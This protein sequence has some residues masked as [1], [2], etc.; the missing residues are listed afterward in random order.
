MPR[1]LQGRTYRGL[2]AGA[3]AGLTAWLLIEK[4]GWFTALL[5][6]TIGIAAG[7]RLYW[8]QAALGALYG[9]VVAAGVC[10]SDWSDQTGKTER[11]RMLALSGLA[12]YLGGAL[13]MLIGFWAYNLILLQPSMSAL[14]NGEQMVI[15]VVARAIGWA[16]IGLAIG[17]AQGIPRRSVRTAWLGAVGGFMGGLAGGGVFE[18]LEIATSNP[19]LARVTGFVFV[20]SAIGFFLEFVPFMMKQAWIQIVGGRGAG[21][22]FLLEKRW[23]SVGRSET[24]DISLFGDRNVA[25]IHFLI[26]TGPS[27]SLLRPAHKSNSKNAPAPIIINGAA[28]DADTPLVGGESIVVS[29]FSLKFNLKNSTSQGAKMTQPHRPSAPPLVDSPSAPPK[30]PRTAYAAS[31]AA[32]LRPEEV[33]YVA[34][35]RRIAD[36]GLTATKL[37]CI[38]GPYFDQIFALATRD[39]LVLGRAADAD[40]PLVNDMAV[41]R[42][43]SAIRLVSGRHWLED[44]K[45]ANGTFINDIRLKH[46]EPVMLKPGDKIKLGDT[47]F[48]YE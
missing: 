4:T 43:H 39:L 6:N 21:N 26:E 13:G 11:I 25:P 27:F 1:T 38:H 41:S 15:G 16:F 3:L 20:G 5:N 42:N 10:L 36:D 45:S 30:L 40:I 29:E 17:A 19:M 23:T 32:P 46:S 8:M 47:M 48:V 44:L 37:H 34:A 28:I 7:S 33:G 24:A 31:K 2:G 14:P 22:E 35:S 18:A 12:G 9:L